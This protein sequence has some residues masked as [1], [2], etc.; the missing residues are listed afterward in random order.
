MPG[1]TSHSENKAWNRSVTRLELEREVKDTISP[2]QV[3]EL[4][5]YIHDHGLLKGNPP[6]WSQALVTKSAKALNRPSLVPFASILVEMLYDA[7]RPTLTREQADLIV[8]RFLLAQQFTL[9]H[10][11]F[12][13]ERWIVPF[14]KRFIDG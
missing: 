7:D 6:R 14:P 12:G 3:A 11:G 13:D 5:T 9:K 8:E 10:Q 4:R 2:A 1:T